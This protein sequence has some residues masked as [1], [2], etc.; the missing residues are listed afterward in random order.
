MRVL[1]ESEGER[2]RLVALA[3]YGILDSPP[4]EAFDRI[5]KL[6]AHLCDA[7]ISLVSLVDKERQWFKS[8]MGIDVIE[9]GRDVSFCEHALSGDDVF[10]VSDASADPRFADN[11]QVVG[12]PGIR[13]YAGAPLIDRS[14]VA[15][16]ALCVIDRKPRPGLTEFE[17][18]ALGY[19]AATVVDLME[20][21]VAGAGYREQLTERLKTQMELERKNGF[22]E[23]LEHVAVAANEA[24]TVEDAL[25]FAVDE[26]C[27]YT[28][29]PIG[30]AFLVD[31]TSGTLRS[32]R[33][34]HVNNEDRFAGFRR[35]TEGATF[36]PGEGTPGRVL[37]TGDYVYVSDL[38]HEREFVRRTAAQGAGLRIAMAFPLLSGSEVVGVLEFLAEQG[39][40]PDDQLLELMNHIST[41]LGRV[42]ERNRAEQAL[43]EARQAA[44]AASRAKSDF[45]SRMSHELRTPLNA[46]LGFAQLLEM[47]S[48]PAE[49]RESVTE[50]RNAGNHLLELINEV[51]DI[52]R[53]ESGKLSLSLEPVALE[54][55]LGESGALVRPL[56]E[57]RRIHVDVSVPPP[58]AS[59]VHADRQRLKQ[60]L[61]NL[62]SNA[63]KYN[64]EGGEVAVTC[65]PAGV[66]QVRVTVSDTGSGIDADKLERLFNPFERLDADQTDVQGTG[67]GLALSARLA[68]AMRGAM[69]VESEAGRG[70]RFW[71]ELPRAQPVEP[72]IEDADERPEAEDGVGAAAVTVLYVEDN[73]ANLRLVE[74][75]L[76]LRPHVR[77]VT[78]T[79]GEG[80]ID[81]AREHHPDLILLDLN[82]PDVGGDEVLRTVRRDPVVSQA[83][84][85][86]LSADATERQRKTLLAAG[87]DAYLTKPID[88]RRL[89]DA[90]EELTQKEVVHE[91][92]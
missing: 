6:A 9:T 37:E 5:T 30:H 20:M 51:L 1:H 14:G 39:E 34:W 23:L 21:R 47:D 49:D 27:T 70:S 16:G 59:F 45:L 52:A 62:L 42:V 72:D 8:R 48:L 46:I 91:V 79:T 4:E 87:A 66:D 84:V 24:A 63:I 22:V 56:A 78:A 38:D 40:E 69:G 7:P 75:V 86:M 33:V 61:L 74:R 28:G 10:V 41:Q 80:G 82:L 77:L 76:A 90:V 19:L 85:A 50:I 36:H 31:S 43:E 71:I 55:V 18:V 35:T 58:D 73:P 60:V 89:L 26:V 12:L 13:F 83:R 17:R 67:L 81:A 88:V 54:G 3:R 68:K 44:E 32:S 11:P 53:I 15:L 2:R 25:Q 92:P 64:A 65:E 57:Q 29:W